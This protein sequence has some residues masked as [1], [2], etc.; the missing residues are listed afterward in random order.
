[1][2]CGDNVYLD[3]DDMST[4]C[5]YRMDF[6]LREI[7]FLGVEWEVTT[8]LSLDS[9]TQPLA[10]YL[11]LERGHICMYK[12]ATIMVSKSYTLPSNIF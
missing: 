2:G 7:N 3:D 5:N 12:H 1:M 8:S 11:Y 4:V 9:C 6:R 10:S